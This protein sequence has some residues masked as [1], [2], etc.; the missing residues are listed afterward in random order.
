MNEQSSNPSLILKL[1]RD[2]LTSFIGYIYDLSMSMF[3]LNNFL[4]FLET[5]LQLKLKQINRYQLNLNKMNM[6]NLQ[7]VPISIS[8]NIRRQI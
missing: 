4:I 6:V 1:R 8:M 2:H 5:Q 7:Q 3:R